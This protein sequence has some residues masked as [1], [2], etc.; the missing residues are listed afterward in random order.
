VYELLGLRV[1]TRLALPAALTDAGTPDVVVDVGDAAPVPSELAEG[2]LL[3][4]RIDAEGE[5]WYCLTRGA[6]G[7][8]LRL[9]G[10]CDL[11]VSADLAAA[12]FTPAE[13]VTEEHLAI[14]LGGTAIS[15]LV[16]LGGSIAL[17]GSA[18]ERDGRALGFLGDSGQG[19]STLAAAC[20]ATGWR[21]LAD[22]A[23][24]IDLADGA[25]CPPGSREIRLRAAPISDPAWPSRRTVDDRLAVS[26]P[27]SPEPAALEALV[28]PFP[29]RGA[30]SVGVSRL[31]A[32]AAIQRV[33]YYLRITGWRDADVLRRT[34]GQAAAIA[35]E[36]PVWEVTVPWG[37][38]F[39]PSMIGE[40]TAAV[41]S[42]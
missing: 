14:I 35:A 19:K 9:P 8:V 1:D 28:I 39:V 17:H 33:L 32:V 27:P 20:C 24:R 6:E 23:L 37:E 16:L 30:T 12:E 15:T 10:L 2:E 4:D 36:V 38:R 31:G 13:G 42:S 11:R 26:P 25:T 7:Y 40:L 21:L 41:T 5:R 34:F 22:D 18:V 3:A 29:D